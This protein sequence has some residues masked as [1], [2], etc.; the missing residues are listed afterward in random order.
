MPEDKD[1]SDGSILGIVFSGFT[2][3]IIVV[4]IILIVIW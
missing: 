1:S 4:A 3:T 2:T